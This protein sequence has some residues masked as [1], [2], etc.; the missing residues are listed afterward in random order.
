[1]LPMQ[2]RRREQTFSRCRALSCCS[3]WP[4]HSNEVWRALAAKLRVASSKQAIEQNE[5]GR[6]YLGVQW[7][8]DASGGETV[9]K[10]VA[11]KAVLAFQ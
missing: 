9:G 11:A 1:M 5:I 7:S 2:V 4:G 8:F 10:A 3:L 6:I